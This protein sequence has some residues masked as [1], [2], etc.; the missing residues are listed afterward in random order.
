[1]IS[2]K[3]IASAGLLLLLVLALIWSPDRSRP[4]DSLSLAYLGVTNTPDGRKLHFFQLTNSLRHSVYG[5]QTCAEVF[6]NTFWFNAQPQ[7]ES[8]PPLQWQSNGLAYAK[9][10]LLAPNSSYEFALAEPTGRAETGLKLQPQPPGEKWRAYVS[11]SAWK[12]PSPVGHF[13]WSLRSKL[14]LTSESEWAQDYIFS[15]PIP[16]RQPVPP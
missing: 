12:Y 14:R 13:M 5:H 7:P 9:V 3:V 10:L 6:H 15:P 1:M 16:F 11:Y 4:L 8:F 2:R